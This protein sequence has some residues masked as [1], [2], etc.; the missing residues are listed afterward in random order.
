MSPLSSSQE[1][2]YERA[3]C[4]S[5]M[6]LI[7]LVM[8]TVVLSWSSVASAAPDPKRKIAVLEYRAG[9]SELNGAARRIAAILDD[10]TGLKVIDPAEAKQLS[11]NTIDRKVAECAGD[12]DCIAE[13]GKSLGADEVL[14]VGISQFGD[15]IL[16][17]QRI[18]AEN[19][20]VEARIAEAMAPGEDP[21]S[22]RW[23][24][25]LERVLPKGD[26][27][28]F[29]TIRIKANLAG[30]TV[31][32][33]GQ[34]RGETPIE[35]VRVPAPQTYD[36]TLNKDGYV[37]FQASVEV[38][39]GGDVMVKPVLEQRGAGDAPLYKKWWVW[40]I[41]GAVVLGTATAIVVA[42]GDD[43]VSVVVGP[44]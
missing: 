33:G 12:T 37:P 44:F 2:G 11:D 13:L 3:K 15:V 14:L 32:I 36:I 17:L 34:E 35:P 1:M 26:F 7:S 22:D 38:P 24:G 43:Q 42:G 8:C 30:A 4:R 40:T 29:G 27:L 18:D 5:V 9:S 23:L 25:Y 10:K 31:I 28:R 6:G 21:G 16:T 39:P 41:A 19:A 20:S